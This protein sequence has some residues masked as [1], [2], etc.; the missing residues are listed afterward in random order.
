MAH[1]VAAHNPHVGAE[2]AAHHPHH[3]DRV[4]GV[5]AP[6]AANAAMAQARLAAYHESHPPVEN[7]DI[8]HTGARMSHNFQHTDQEL[9][10]SAVSVRELAHDEITF[11]NPATSG[12]RHL[13]PAHHAP[14]P[15]NA[16]I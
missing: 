11:V 9:H 12:P 10:S 7:I 13:P 5:R 1:N 3:D 15:H 6:S 16:G 14:P 8:K 2:D 4:F